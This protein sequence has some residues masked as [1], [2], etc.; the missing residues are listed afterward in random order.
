MYVNTMFLECNYHKYIPYFIFKN[1]CHISG[2]N[3]SYK[4]NQI[5][6]IKARGLVTPMRAS[7]GERAWFV[8]CKSDESSMREPSGNFLAGEIDRVFSCGKFEWLTVM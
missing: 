5:T 8:R 4:Y 3:I 6:G 2:V 7:E 1:S